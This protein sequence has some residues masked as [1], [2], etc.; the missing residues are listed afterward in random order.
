MGVFSWL[1]SKAKEFVK[2]I[3]D[4]VSSGD[5]VSPIKNMFSGVF[6]DVKSAVGNIASNFMGGDKGDGDMMGNNGVPI[7]RQFVDSGLKSIR[8]RGGTA[9]QDLMEPYGKR[10]KRDMN[11]PEPTE[12]NNRGRTRDAY[13]VRQEYIPMPRES[14]PKREFEEEEE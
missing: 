11:M 9:I 2:P 12:Y 6:D 13:T 3:V 8:R 14:F 7:Y 10:A 4:L 5:I 1:F